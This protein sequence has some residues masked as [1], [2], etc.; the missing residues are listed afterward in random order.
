MKRWLAVAVVLVSFSVGAAAQQNNTFKVRPVHP[1]KAPKKAA[2]IDN[3][4][5]SKAGASATSKSLR[6]LEHQTAKAAGPSRSAPKKSPALK[7]VKEKANPPINFGAK[8]G[9]GMGMTN[10]GSNSYQGRLKQKGTGRH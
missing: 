4:G 8:G 6:S 9:K 7:P 2:P 1:E 5:S 3:G 10:Q